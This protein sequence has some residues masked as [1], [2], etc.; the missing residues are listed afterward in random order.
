ME[1]FIKIISHFKVFHTYCQLTV[2]GGEVLG[3]RNAVLKSPD[4]KFFSAC[5]LILSLGR[6]RSRLH[7][8]QTA[9]SCIFLSFLLLV[10]ADKGVCL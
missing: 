1:V 3:A 8:N 6:N 4:L 10:F 5:H 2:G 9:F 7:G